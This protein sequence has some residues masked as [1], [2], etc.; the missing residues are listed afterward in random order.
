MNQKNKV[1]AQEE[2]KMSNSYLIDPN[3]QSSRG[4]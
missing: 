2:E 3:D 1:A 4:I